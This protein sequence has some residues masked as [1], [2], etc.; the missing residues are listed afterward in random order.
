MLR[1][2]DVSNWQRGLKLTALPRLDFCIVKA[3]EGLNI[4]DSCCDNFVEQAKSL[5]MLWGFYHF[6]RPNSPIAEANKFYKETKNYFGHGIPVLD[7]EDTNIKDWNSYAETFC[8]RI[9]ELSNIWP[10]FY[11][12]RAGLSRITSKLVTENCPL[13]V[14]SLP[15]T[16]H[17]NF[18]SVSYSWKTA[19]WNDWKVWQFSWY[20]RLSGWNENLDLDYA[21]L[22]YEEW[23]QLANPD[24]TCAYEKR[25]N[26][27]FENEAMKIEVNLK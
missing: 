5:G 19:N 20:G 18:D 26:Y 14:A 21:D 22:T 8:N 10:M 16:K 9:H 4:V 7:L 1:G 11:S 25:D 2:I 15:Q 24:A 13:W 27:V 17:T 12:Y 6:A 3:T 23:T